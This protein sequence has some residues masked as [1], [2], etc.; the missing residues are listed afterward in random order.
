MGFNK[1]FLWGSASAAYQIEGGFDADG[2]GQSVWDVWA[3]LPGK[4]YKGTH[5]D[6]AADHY[7]RYQEDIDLM[8]EMGLKTYRFSM[9]WTRLLPEGTGAVNEAGIDFYMKLI[10]GLLEKNIVPLVTL[11]HWDLPQALQDKYAGWLSP[12]V[13]DDFTA[14]AT[15]CFERF[16]H[17]VKHWIVMNEPNI[18]TSLGYQLALHPPGEKN[19]AHF[20]LAY[21]HTALAHAKTVLL[22][23]Q[24]GFPGMIG[25]SI[26]Y[27]PGHPITESAEDKRAC[28]LYNAFGPDWYLDS[29]YKGVYPAEAVAYY[30]EKGIMPLVSAQ[31]IALLKEAA[32]KA[33][34]IGI[35]YYQT[36]TLAHNPVDGVGFSGMN[37][38]GEKGSQSENGVPGLFKHVKNP[39]LQHTD[40]DWAIDPKGLSIGLKDLWN[41]YQKPLLISENGFGAIDV[42]ND[43]GM[44]IDDQRIQY[45]SEHIDACRDAVD[46]G[47]DL[48]GYCTWSF[49]DLLSWLNG[50]HKRYGFVYVDYEGGTLTRIP[51]KSFDWYKEVIANNGEA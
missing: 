10:D 23:K 45:L 14:Y 6:V 33:D 46:S 20:L 24:K 27:G 15:L 16:G 5:G 40:W 3:H 49:T 26:A 8:A 39:K 41:R 13:V 35:N 2:K 30:E 48:L 17:K 50:Y 1:D 44:I 19:D 34:F 21:H 51:K 25:S 31:D 37:T 42:V 47:V 22:F 4:T 36:A 43:E 32:E 12:Q 7:H 29:Y 28:D 11:Y 38:T 9:A 18:F